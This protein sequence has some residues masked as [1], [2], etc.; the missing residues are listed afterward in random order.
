MIVVPPACPSTSSQRTELLKD[1]YELLN[2]QPEPKRNGLLPRLKST[3]QERGNGEGRADS[4]ERGRDYAGGIA[5]MNGAEV[6][7]RGAVTNITVTALRLP[8]VLVPPFGS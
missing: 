3:A 8:C 1:L 5:A 4:A 7:R 2:E 6:A